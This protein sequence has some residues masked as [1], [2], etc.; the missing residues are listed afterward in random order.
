MADADDLTLVRK[1]ADALVAHGEWL[2]TAESCT[3]GG[4]AQ[5]LT[6][7]PGSSS[8]FER[9]YV[10]YSNRSKTEMLGVPAEL[11]A[12]H[13]AVSEEVVRAMAEGAIARSGADHAVAVSGI[14]GPTGGSP[15]KPVGTVWIAW[16]VRGGGT[17]ATRHRFPG[18]REQI[19]NASVRAAL[20]GLHLG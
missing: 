18:D 19:R 4:L 7:V 13:G 16:S 3:G 14:A 8:W 1:I 12:T 9:G 10:T 6:S 11:I 5:L 20:E 2:V 17:R 15:E